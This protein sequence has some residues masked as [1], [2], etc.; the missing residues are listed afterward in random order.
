MSSEEELVVMRNGEKKWL[1]TTRVPLRNDQQENIGLVG[2]S[3]DITDRK[4]IE[5]SLRVSVERSNILSRATNDAIWDW[6]LVTMC[7]ME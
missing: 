7:A 1:L 4:K 3:R 2:I 5:E 6:D